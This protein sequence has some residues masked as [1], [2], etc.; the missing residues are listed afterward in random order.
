[1]GLCGRPAKKWISSLHITKRTVFENDR[2]ESERAWR[3][4][5]QDHKHPRAGREQLVVLDEK[6]LI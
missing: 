6:S 2:I 4:A 3:D 5:S 1:M